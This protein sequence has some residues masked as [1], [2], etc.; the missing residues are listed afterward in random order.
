VDIVLT[1]GEEIEVDLI[2]TEVLELLVV[3]ICL[4]QVIEKQCIIFNGRVE[5]RNLTIVQDV[6]D[7]FKE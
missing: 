2:I 5:I 6:V 7:I 3:L 4:S 1:F